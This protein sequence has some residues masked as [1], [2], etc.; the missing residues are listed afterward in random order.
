MNE[1]EFD[2]FFSEKLNKGGEF[3]NKDKNWNKIANHLDNNNNNGGGIARYWWASVMLL[4]LG[5]NSCQWMTIK[6]M[7]ADDI[8][9]KKE[10]V[11]L[12]NTTF[13]TD[14]ITNTRVIYQRDTIYKRIYI[15]ENA[16]VSKNLE[17]EDR[18][19]TLTTPSVG[20]LDKQESVII[21]N[22]K[23]FKNDS[24][25]IINNDEKASLKTT[26]L[27]DSL[28]RKSN[29]NDD[30]IENKSNEMVIAGTILGLHHS[31]ADSLAAVSTAPVELA[32]DSFENALKKIA[33]PENLTKKE[34]KEIILKR[35]IKNIDW[36]VGANFGIS[37]FIDKVDG[38]KPA[39]WVGVSGEAGFNRHWRM[40]LSVDWSKNKYKI[41]NPDDYELIHN[42]PIVD[43]PAANYEFLYAEGK[44]QSWQFGINFNYNIRPASIFKPFIK[45]GY[46]YRIVKAYETEY[47]FRNKLTGEER[48]I[49][50]NSLKHIDNWWQLGG[51]VETMLSKRISTR[52]SAEYIHDFNHT[53]KIESSKPLNYFLLRG[54]IFLKL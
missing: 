34:K 4:L 46:I 15:F 39:T 35:N 1:R 9:L 43:L 42:L 53:N 3:P 28:T 36:L 50:R 33:E 27:K 30:K 22:G 26:P 31:K 24:N 13:K 18:L 49:M 2:K 40:G 54:A 8:I 16:I 12:K 37:S 51:G 47:E 44:P 5:W 48:Y 10:M 29:V 17:T 32:L 38:V 11:K 20:Q 23:V 19:P 7:R 14:T 25:N 52:F 41:T 45:A 6:E 21:T